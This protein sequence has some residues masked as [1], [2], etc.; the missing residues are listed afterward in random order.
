MYIFH[1][2]RLLKLQWKQ[3]VEEPVKLIKEAIALDEKCEYA[4]EM[5]GTIEVQR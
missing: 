4:Y 1:F 3:N 2:G 5:L